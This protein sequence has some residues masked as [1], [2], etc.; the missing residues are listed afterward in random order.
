LLF[1]CFALADVWL[2][3]GVLLMLFLLLTLVARIRAE[4]ILRSVISASLRD[5]N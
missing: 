5:R 1:E 3:R 2:G 4:R